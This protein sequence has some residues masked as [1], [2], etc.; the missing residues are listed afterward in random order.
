MQ[1][2]K[3]HIGQAVLCGAQHDAF[4][5]QPRV[6]AKGRKLYMKAWLQCS[7]QKQNVLHEAWSQYSE[8]ITGSMPESSKDVIPI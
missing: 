6:D 1:F 2:Q 7:S 5:S 8:S 4:K 3:P